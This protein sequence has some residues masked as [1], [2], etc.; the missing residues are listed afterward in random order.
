MG[1]GTDAGNGFVAAAAASVLGELDCHAV[2][3]A[4]VGRFTEA[5]ESGE[6]VDLQ[7]SGNSGNE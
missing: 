2:V 4:G 1:A 7:E 3:A 6:E 5:A